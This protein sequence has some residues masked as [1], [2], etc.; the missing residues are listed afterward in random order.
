MISQTSIFLI[1][2]SSIL[3]VVI[4][5]MGIS[6]VSGAVYSI[7]GSQM[8]SKLLSENIQSDPS[9]IAGDLP[10]GRVI[11]FWNTHCGACHLAWDF[12]D[13][14]IP[15]HPEVEILNY[16]LYNSTDNRTLF[17]NYKEKYH[18]NQL[19]IPSMIVGNITLEGTQDIRNHLPEILHLQQ[20]VH[21]SQG[22]I[23][24]LQKFINNLHLF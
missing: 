15:N 12:I 2:V 14:F 17:E 9:L 6:P 23:V 10:R 11:F 3:I 22:I 20:E 1:S 8:D 7:N 24:D 21:S 18:R 19:S 13:E 5:V 16:D 4:L